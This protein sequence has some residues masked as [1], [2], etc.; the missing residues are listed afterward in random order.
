MDTIRKIKV[1]NMESRN[2][3]LVPNQFIIYTDDGVYFQS[4]TTIIAFEPHEERGKVYLDER[5][6][7]CSRTTGKYRN[8]FL[9]EGI[10][11]TR[12]KIKEGTYVLVNWLN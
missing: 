8:E 9:G 11:E 2:G 7:D 1:R 12:R 10:A 6:W 4:Y 5:S 3:N